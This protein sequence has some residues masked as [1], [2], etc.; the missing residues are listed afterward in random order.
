MKEIV[1]HT[2]TIPEAKPKL[3]LDLSHVLARSF[4]PGFPSAFQHHLAAKRVSAAS[5]DKYNTLGSRIKTV[6]LGTR[7]NTLHSGG[8]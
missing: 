8:S 3:D 1:D 5:I 6:S 2:Q 4:K 7:S